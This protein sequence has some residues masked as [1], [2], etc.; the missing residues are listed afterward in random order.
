MPDRR[1][2]YALAANR[3]TATS[4]VLGGRGEAAGL[5]WLHHP[6]TPTRSPPCRGRRFALPWRRVAPGFA[7]RARAA[8]CC[9]G[10]L[11]V[12]VSVWRGAAERDAGVRR[13]VSDNRQDGNPPRLARAPRGALRGPRPSAPP[14]TF[15][16][17]PVRRTPVSCSAAPRYAPEHAR[18]EP[19]SDC[20]VPPMLTFPA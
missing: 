10:N 19:F 15:A 17:R 4:R 1:R 16:R 9:V 13:R 20:A 12:H 11:V 7:L 5:V 3:A 18:R 8:A 14:A 2:R 6:P